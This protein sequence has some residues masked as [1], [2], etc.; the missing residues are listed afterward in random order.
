MSFQI[1]SDYNKIDHA[2]WSDFVFNHPKGNI[3]QTPQMIRVY[4]KTDNYT[5][6]SL[7]AKRDSKI[8]G[9]LCT[10]LQKE[11]KGFVGYFSSRCI[12]WG[13]PLI[14]NNCKETLNLILSELINQLKNKAIFIQFRN[15]FD[16]AEYKLE[17]SK[18]G[19]KYEKHLDIHIDI[20]KSYELLK[21]KIH[22]SRIRNLN[23]SLRKGIYIQ[24]LLSIEEIKEGYCLVNQT[25]NRIKSLPPHFT[26]FKAIHEVLQANQM[27]DFYGVYLENQLI[28]VRLVL[29]YK[30][31]IYDY[32]AGSNHDESNKYPNDVL[33]LNIIEK[34]CTDEK[35]NLFIFGG[36]GKPGITYGVREHKLQFGGYL[37]EYGRFTRVNNLF[38]YKIGTLGL[39]IISFIK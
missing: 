30:G 18:H 7:F 19:F 9:I 17:Y 16:Q 12:I 26:L 33:I 5:P 21:N 34:G 13:G 22:K 28:G 38:M 29:I 6:I 10:V 2:Q 37:V 39:K 35:L 11:S 36:A 1:V 32:Y 27:A 15:I 25:Y 23:K 31:V 24:Q 20:S 8:V 4:A 14:E 3:F